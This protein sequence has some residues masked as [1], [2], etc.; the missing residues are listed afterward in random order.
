MRGMRIGMVAGFL[1]TA[2][3]AWAP[4]AEPAER[5]PRFAKLT[6]DQLNAYQKPLGE[7][8]LAMADEGVP[9]GKEPPFKPGEP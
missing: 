4:D 9:P 5:A 6:Y 8:I 7:Q 1:F 3:P 2:F